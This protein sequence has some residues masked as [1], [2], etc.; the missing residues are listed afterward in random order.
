M[1]G[2]DIFDRGDR[3]VSCFDPGVFLSTTHVSTPANSSLAASSTS[4]VTSSGSSGRR[5]RYSPYSLSGERKLFLW[6]YPIAIPKADV[7][8]GSKVFLFLSNQVKDFS[9]PD[10]GPLHV[11]KLCEL[12]PVYF[13]ALVTTDKVNNVV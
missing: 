8:I 12:I 11:F 2:V 7:V 6:V 1:G 9:L 13:H 10:Q 5:W 3:L 4:I